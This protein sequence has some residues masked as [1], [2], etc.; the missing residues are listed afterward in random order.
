MCRSFG[1]GT[2]T[3]EGTSGELIPKGTMIML[4]LWPPTDIY[5]VVYR[6]IESQVSPSSFSKSPVP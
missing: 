6:G 3:L 5:T 1:E 2:G 4:P